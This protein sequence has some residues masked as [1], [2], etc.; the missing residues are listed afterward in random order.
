VIRGQPLFRGD[1]R[2]I[3]HLLTASGKRT[4]ASVAILLVLAGLAATA[5]VVSAGWRSLPVAGVIALLCLTTLLGVQLLGYVELS[6][7]GNRLVR[8]LRMFRRRG[9]TLVQVAEAARHIRG[10]SA[11][12]DLRR[13]LEGLVE[14]GVLEEVSIRRRDGEPEAAPGDAWTLETR[15]AS[16]GYVLVA[17]ARADDRANVRPEDI[18]QYLVPAIE[19]T[20]DRLVRDRPGPA[21]DVGD[22]AA[23]KELG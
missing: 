19:H 3:H 13:R 1:D 22:V 12:P 6:V 11:W 20:M 9:H 5:A 21:D 17:R 4:D 10:A 7:L 18:R 23:A 14:A 8:L 2:H 16:D 15:L